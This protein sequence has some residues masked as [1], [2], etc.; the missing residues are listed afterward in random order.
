MNI[1]DQYRKMLKDWRNQHPDQRKL[2]DTSILDILLDQISKSNPERVQKTGI[3]A[4]GKIIWR[5]K[6]IRP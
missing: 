3:D 6:A 5:I 1:P 2:P 4:S